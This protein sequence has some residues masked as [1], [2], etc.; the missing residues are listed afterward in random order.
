MKFPLVFCPLNI[1]CLLL[2]LI[3]IFY[4]CFHSVV[5]GNLVVPHI[6]DAIQEWVERVA[7]IPVDE[8]NRKPQVCIIEVRAFLSSNSTACRFLHYT[9]IYPPSAVTQRL[10]EFCIMAA[11]TLLYH[12]SVVCTVPSYRGTC[13]P[14]PIP[15]RLFEFCIVDICTLL[16]P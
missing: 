14:S 4:C 1:C 5:I 7:Q 8:D 9:G 3:T 11:R 10:V 13:L 16:I 2:I 12:N 15:Q 6:T